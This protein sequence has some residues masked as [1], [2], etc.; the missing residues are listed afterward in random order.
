[1][2]AECSREESIL[3]WANPEPFKE[4]LKEL[5]NVRFYVERRGRRLRRAQNAA[6]YF[7]FS[8]PNDINKIKECDKI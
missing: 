5:K 2:K 8:I 7:G 1:M 4:R 3:Y 6:Q